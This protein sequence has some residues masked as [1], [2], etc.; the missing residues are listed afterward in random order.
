MCVMKGE[1]ACQVKAYNKLKT[2]ALQLPTNVNLLFLLFNQLFVSIRMNAVTT[3]LNK[4][5]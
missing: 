1:I 3:I 5:K 2:T 4:I